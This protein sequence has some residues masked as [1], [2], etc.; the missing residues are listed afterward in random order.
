MEYNLRVDK[1]EFL[2]IFGLQMN[3]AIMHGKLIQSLCH[4]IFVALPQFITQSQ[5]MVC[6]LTSP[7][8]QPK[9]HCTPENLAEI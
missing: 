4:L 2:F 3:N 1:Y 6:V 8:M 7:L 5:L 9:S